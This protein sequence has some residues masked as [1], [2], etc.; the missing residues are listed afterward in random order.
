MAAR[1]RRHSGRSA[2]PPGDPRTGITGKSSPARG[3]KYTRGAAGACEAAAR[4]ALEFVMREAAHQGR[5]G[6]T[7]ARPAELPGARGRRDF[8]NADGTA[9]EF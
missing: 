3:A 6:R 9:F 8:A 1:E 2:R 7:C 5:P 4:A